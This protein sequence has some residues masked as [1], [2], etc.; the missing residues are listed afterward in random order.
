AGNSSS[1]SA[2]GISRS[3]TSG[4]SGGSGEGCMIGAMAPRTRAEDER[5]IAAFRE[6]ALR[7][8]RMLREARTVSQRTAVLRRID[9]LL[10]EL[11]EMAAG[12]LKEVLPLH[13]RDGSDEAIRQLRK[14]RGFAEQID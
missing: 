2:R 3:S 9:A 8:S 5:L 1:A 12:Y 6:A 13:F 7:I 11:D 4:R 14:L 10:A